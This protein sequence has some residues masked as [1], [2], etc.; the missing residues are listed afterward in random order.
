[1]MSDPADRLLNAP[2][3][4]FDRRFYDSDQRISTIGAG[5][6]GGKAQG[7]AMLNDLIKYDFETAQFGRVE[8][9]VPA[10]T[11]IRTGVFDA[12]MGRNNLYEVIASEN[13]DYRITQKF[14]A[15]DLPFEIVGD[16]RALVQNPRGPLAIRSSSLL[17]DATY[18]PFAG[19]YATKMIPNDQYDASARFHN[20]VEA[21]KF[22]YAST[23]YKNAKSYRE[24][25]RHDHRE[26]KMAIIIQEVVGKRHRNR[27]YPEL[28]GVA[29][30]YNFYPVGRAKQ[31][32]GVVNLALGLG[33]TVVD[34]GISWAYSPAYPRVGPPFG[35]TRALLEG[36]QKTYWA[37]DMGAPP[38]LQPQQE[39]EYL[40]Q[41][42]LSM[43]EKDDTLRHV[44]STYNP[45][46]DRIVMGVGS[47]G[48]RVLNFAPLLQIRDI[49]L[50]EILKSFLAL[51]EEEMNLPVEIEF[52]MT[53]DPHRL[54]FLQARPMVVSSAAIDV[55]EE[56]LQGENILAASKNVLGN[57]YVDDVQDII[58]VIPD[59]FRK[60][61]TRR[62]ARELERFNQTLVAEQRP[63][64]LF[65]FGRLGSSDPWLG[66]PVSWGQIS[67]VRVIVEATQDGFFVEMSQGSHFFHNLTSL[68]VSYFSLPRHQEFKVDWNWLDSQTEVGATRYVRHIR[69]EKPLAIK[70][71]GRTGLGVV[72]KNE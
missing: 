49:P 58:Y 32:E 6:L 45:Q 61:N 36:S 62:I 67:G 9:N 23:F 72:A 17:E 2:I 38:A 56:D 59:N 71:D 18:E 10:M 35:S 24:V 19:I 27:F 43:A 41:E 8:I 51:C 53:F 26:E 70:M 64:L 34:G 37:I 7:L 44:S 3:G 69:L 30:S 14:L 1:M 66:I 48:P 47:Q 63:Y 68:G 31:E 13:S 39:F 54:G 55:K 12:F 5:S 4:P 33:K 22:I 15:A 57:G 25:T 29:R 16:L 42:D 11:V 52:A 46:S 20:L 40:I 50:N 21:I 65:V 60:E 28:S